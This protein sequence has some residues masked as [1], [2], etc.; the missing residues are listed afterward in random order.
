MT[1]WASTVLNLA[2]VAKLRQLL[3]LP[4]GDVL[5]VED[6]DVGGVM[7]PHVSDVW[8][9]PI[10]GSCPGQQAVA[11]MGSRLVTSDDATDIVVVDWLTDQANRRG[12]TVMMLTSGRRVR[13]APAEDGAAFEGRQLRWGDWI[14]TPGAPAGFAKLATRDRVNELADRADGIERDL[15]D[16]LEEL[17]S[18]T[19]PDHTDWAAEVF[20]DQLIALQRGE[21]RV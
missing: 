16:W 21:V 5:L 18:R 1:T 9:L 14:R 8:G 20:V 2:I 15:L 7:V 17:G 6:G 12:S 19:D 3:E 11:E 4:A 13:L 10:E